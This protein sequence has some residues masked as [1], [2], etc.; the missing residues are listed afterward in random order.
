MGDIALTKSA[1][2]SAPTSQ[3]IFFTEK[4]LWLLLP[5]GNVPTHT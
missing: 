5:L 4:V 2:A 3:S 1:M